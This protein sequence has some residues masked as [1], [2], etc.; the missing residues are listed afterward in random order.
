M[1]SVSSVITFIPT[2]GDNH[3]KPS[4]EQIS[5]KLKPVGMGKK[6]QQLVKFIN[7]APDKLMAQMMDVRQQDEIKSLLMDHVIRFVNFT[8]DGE[9]SSDDVAN[10]VTIDGIIL[11]AV[12]QRWSRP[13]T[14]KDIFDLGEYELAMEIFM[15][16]IGS[17]QL[18]KNSTPES[19][20]VTAGEDNG[21]EEKNSKSPS[22]LLLSEKQIH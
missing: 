1:A 5:V 22:G 3:G 7:T 10:N 4:E 18:R 13:F 15:F 2:I 9:A 19:A 16:M 8:V 11:T 20:R 12:G 21:D 14:V 6:Q 17:S